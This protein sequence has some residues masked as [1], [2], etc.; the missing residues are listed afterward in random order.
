MTP[1]RRVAQ[2]RRRGCG[3]RTAEIR[4]RRLPRLL[5]AALL[6][7]LL[8]VGGAAAAEPPVRLSF[9]STFPGNM[10]LIGEAATE[11]PR[12]IARATGG[13]VELQYHE[14]GALVPATETLFAVSRGIVD[15]GWGGAGWFSRVD[16]A[17]NMF[18]AVPFGPGIGEYLAWLYYGGGLE[19][20]RELFAAHRLHNV[21]CALIPP[22]ASGWFR[23]EIRSVADLR[24]LRMRFFGLGA[25][26]MQKLG[27][28]TRQLPPGEIREELA[29]GRLDAAEFSLPIM[30]Q[31]LGLHEVARYHYFPGWHQQ[32]TFFDL[33]VHVPVW[34][35][36]ADRHRAVIELACGDMIR[37]SIARGEARQWRAMQEMRA[38]GVQT[39]RWTPEIIA[40]MESAWNEVVAEE[41]ARSPNFRRV[42]AS[43]EAFRSN[44]AIWRDHAYL[45]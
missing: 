34:T 20:A 24:G 27:V 40:A 5:G 35:A 18:S 2:S 39:R 3:Y 28:D 10:K 41:S 6:G 13:E 17:F 38:T 22:E 7:S 43:Y 16:S 31:S 23:R 4:L 8:V 42:Y 30:D 12:T 19:L 29:Q 25:Q 36:L 33:Y 15:A 11:L 32:A 45:K 21:P 9:A 44:Y 1:A 14:P 37:E 26:V